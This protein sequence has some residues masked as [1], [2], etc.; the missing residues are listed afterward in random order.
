MNPVMKLDL[1]DE[2]KSESEP[3]MKTELKLALK[4]YM[5]KKN[6]IQIRPKI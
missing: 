6:Q 3:E 2:I 1:N 5:Q 4:Q